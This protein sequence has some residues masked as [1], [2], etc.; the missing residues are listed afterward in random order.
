MNRYICIWLLFFAGLLSGKIVQAQSVLYGTL[1]DKQTD[2]AITNAVCTASEKGGRIVGYALSDG[3]GKYRFSFH[4]EQDSLLFTVSHLNYGKTSRMIA[5][6][7]DRID[8]LLEE[9]VFDL[10]EVKVK[11][12]PVWSIGDTITYRV[13]NFKSG[14]DRVIGDLLKKIP[15]VEVKENGTI[16][17]QEKPINRFYIEGMDLLE[18]KYSI[19]TNNLPVDAVDRVQVLE[20]HQ[21]VKAL[22]DVDI[23]A[24][25]ALNLKLKDNKMARPM[26]TARL[27]AGTSFSDP[28]WLGEAFIFQ[29]DGKQQRIG[30]LK[31]NNTGKNIA[32]DLRDHMLD[33][34]YR[35]PPVPSG[36]FQPASLFAPPVTESRYLDNDSWLTTFNQLWKLSEASQIRLAL[37]YLNDRKKQ[38]SAESDLFFINHPD[39]LLA[40]EE[41]SRLRKRTDRGEMELT[42]TCNSAS[43]YI[44]EKLKIQGGWERSLS[45]VD[46]S[47]RRMQHFH[48]PLFFVENHLNLIRQKEKKARQFYSFIRYSRQPQWL[49]V[50]TDSLSA[51]NTG[52]LRQHTERNVFYTVN[53][54][55]FSKAWNTSLFYTELQFKAG[56]ERLHS[57]IDSLPFPLAAGIAP[58]NRLKWNRYEYALTP[59]YTWKKEKGNLEVYLPLTL[60]DLYADNRSEGGSRKHI[61]R[62]SAEPSVSYRYV[63]NPYLT[64]TLSVEY[65]RQTG[66]MLDFAD[67]V[68]MLDF[69]RFTYGSGVLEERESGSVNWKFNYRNPLRILFAN[70]SATY[71][72]Q[73]SNLLNN[74]SFEGYYFLNSRY[75]S[76]N[77]YRII[78]LNAYTAKYLT[79]LYTNVVLTTGYSGSRRKQI[80][81]GQELRIT[82]HIYNASLKTNTKIGNKAST[83]FGMEW[84]GSRPSGRKLLSQWSPYFSC[85]YFPLASWQFYLKGEYLL[86]ELNDNRQMDLFFAD[87]GVAYKGK[88]WD[89]S[90]DASNLFD[91]KR[92]GYATYDGVNTHAFYYRLRGREMMLTVGFSF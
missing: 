32:A 42:Y 21:P 29:A 34:I 37:H 36:L 79:K 58:G 19:A 30:T 9:A 23:S 38:Q 35:L 5:H 3:E 71:R 84:V 46:G 70:F 13:E 76:D 48:M 11:S 16:Y 90:L 45:D 82:H 40:V 56:L 75:K 61:T 20:N 60:L 54:T 17:Y 22:K 66:D 8:L 72:I 52:M 85:H 4:S 50:T 41:Y 86:N 18:S 65:N 47:L 55:S 2:A 67:G 59:R 12:A 89:I 57:D 43:L 27:A 14:E 7:N 28:L 53:K 26:V 33:F 64:S 88:G 62:F 15:G 44:N 25:A 49:K 87:A 69:R 74:T 24:Q 6:K 78:L 10:K 31:G 83:A 91:K 51:G 68:R 92:Y 77:R 1:R 81:Q 39:S 63:I 80:Q 73:E